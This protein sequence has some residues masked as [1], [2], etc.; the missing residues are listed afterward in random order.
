MRKTVSG[1]LFGFLFSGVAAVLIVLAVAVY[2]PWRYAG[3]AISLNPDDTSPAYVL[4]ALL[5][6]YLLIAA[7]LAVFASRT[8]NTRPVLGFLLNVTPLPAIIALLFLRVSFR[9]YA[10]RGDRTRAIQI[11]ISDAPAIHLGE[12]YVKKVDRPG[13]ASLFLHVP[14]IVDR[15]V[16]SNSLNILVT[17][18]EPDEGVRYSARPE[19]NNAATDPPYGFHVVDREF[20]EPPL[21]VYTSGTRIIRGQLNPGVQYYLLRQLDFAPMCRVSDYADFDPKQITVALDLAAAKEYLE[22]R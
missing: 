20:T 21:P 5:G 1:Y 17:S 16:E 3:N 18:K 7:G 13:G 2:L 22:E 6:V 10:H 14:V 12:P 9:D 8:F 4:L 15:T 11:A 19:C